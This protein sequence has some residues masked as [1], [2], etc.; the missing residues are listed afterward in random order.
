MWNFPLSVCFSFF[1]SLPCLGSTCLWLGW[2]T[3]LDARM[4][5]WMQFLLSLVLN[6]RTQLPGET[7]T[8]PLPRT[9]P[10]H[11]APPAGDTPHRAVTT[12]ANKVSKHQHLYACL[13]KFFIHAH[14]HTR[15]DTIGNTA[16]N[17]TATA[18]FF[19]PRYSFYL[20]DDPVF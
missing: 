6:L 1:L 18:S 5:G 10:A 16:V 11:R 7:T 19:S 4:A 9:Q 20:L 15:H 2:G 3:P 14:V 12:A 8:T 17:F 13:F